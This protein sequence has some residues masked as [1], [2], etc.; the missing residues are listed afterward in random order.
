MSRVLAQATVDLLES[1]PMPV[2]EVIVTGQIQGE[3][4]QVRRFY[5]ISAKTDDN[6]AQE[7]IRRFMDEMENL[8]S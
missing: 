3:G 6:A 5:T 2:W 7:G 1:G 4:G 8:L